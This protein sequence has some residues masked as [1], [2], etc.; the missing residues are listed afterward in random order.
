MLYCIGITIYNVFFHPLA[1]YPGPLLAKITPLYSLWGLLRG[2]WPF[3]AHQ[4]HMKYGPV[5]RLMPNEVSFTS[6]QAWK[7]ICGHRQGHP[8]FHKDPIQ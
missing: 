6:P 5:V 1:K 8:Q 4:L 2:R 7:D 3:D